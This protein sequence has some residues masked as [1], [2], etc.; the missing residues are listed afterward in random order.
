MNNIDVSQNL[1]V[2]DMTNNQVVPINDL[3]QSQVLGLDQTQQQP[4]SP[5]PTD[6]MDNP[7]GQQNDTSLLG[8]SPGNIHG[9]NLDGIAA[10]AI[11]QV[12]PL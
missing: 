3:S 12:S 1:S 9:R 10:T 8:V 7:K 2:F 4:T 5:I 11:N 6:K